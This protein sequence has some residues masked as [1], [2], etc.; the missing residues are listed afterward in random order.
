LLNLVFVMP[1]IP[2]PIGRGNDAQLM[3]NQCI[4]SA[5]PARNVT[6]GAA[7]TWHR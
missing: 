2:L 7:T 4:S 6:T 1:T 5:E 3:R